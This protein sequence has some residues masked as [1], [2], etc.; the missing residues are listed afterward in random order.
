[1]AFLVITSG[2]CYGSLG[3]G[4]IY[5]AE[6]LLAKMPTQLKSLVEK[7]KSAYLAGANGVDIIYWAYYK[8]FFLYW[9]LPNS[10]AAEFDLHTNT[11]GYHTGQTALDILSEAK[12]YSIKEKAFALGWLTHWLTDAYVHTLIGHYGGDYRDNEDPNKCTPTGSCRHT[13]L[14]LAESK[15]LCSSERYA[16]YGPFLSTYT[17]SKGDLPEDFIEDLFKKHKFV[18]AKYKDGYMHGKGKVT[19][20]YPF[21]GKRIED[22]ESDFRANLET[23]RA[24][25]Q[26]AIECIQSSCSKKSNDCSGTQTG[27]MSQS[28]WQQNKQSY[29]LDK[30]DYIDINNAIR[31]N[32]DKL[33]VKDGSLRAVIEANDT[34][35]YGKFLVEW[36]KVISDLE[37][38]VD[39]DQLF[40]IVQAF[41]GPAE[42]DP[43]EKKA[44]EALERVLKQIP[45][46]LTPRNQ[47]HLFDPETTKR[48]A[49][50]TLRGAP[51]I[52]RIHYEI[53]STCDGGKTFNKSHSNTVPITFHALDKQRIK[54]FGSKS[55]SAVIDVALEGDE[56]K[57][58]QYVLLVSVVSPDTGV[59]SY[60]LGTAE[61][62][63]VKKVKVLTRKPTA[64]ADPDFKFLEYD[65]VYGDY[66]KSTDVK[67]R[68]E[69]KYE[70]MKSTIPYLEQLIQLDEKAF[71]EFEKAVRRNVLKGVVSGKYGAPPVPKECSGISRDDMA[72][73]IAEIEKV[74]PNA[75]KCGF[76]LEDPLTKEKRWGCTHDPQYQK[77]A[78][79]RSVLEICLK[80]Q[81][82]V[83]YWELKCIDTPVR[84]R[85]EHK[86]ML[87]AKLAA[88][89]DSKAY[90][91]FKEY[92]GY[93]DYKGYLKEI[94]GT[95]KE[96][97]LPD[98]IPSPVE[99]PWTYYSGTCGV[100]GAVQEAGKLQIQL[101]KYPE[102]N[103]YNVG[104]KITFT[105]EPTGGKAP[106]SFEWTGDCEGKDK[107]VAV[108][109]SKIGQ[110]RLKVSV[111][112]FRGHHG[113]CGCC[114]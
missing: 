62:G 27:S 20:Q 110:N 19:R 51:D 107:S 96:L 98:P 36:D 48:Y 28:V 84:E 45:N 89:K 52:T 34:Q 91:F 105:A 15:H 92:A 21:V 6:K 108:P 73:R 83:N 54:L 31:I 57:P 93:N 47:M 60:M 95:K 67:S 87:K 35:L 82:P 101:T 78:N 11:L 7:E 64:P 75:Y 104:E 56:D 69:A 80:G 39:K 86:E 63:G 13:Q 25:V 2:F 72:R 66:K 16:T 90:R 38:F 17:L 55:G 53:A 43:A 58:C 114:L 100:G 111:R 14:E 26:S 97:S 99:L 18:A 113:R 61:D 32:V 41:I 42:A 68:A 49:D 24:S 29:L 50:G 106:Y 3:Q 65:W 85:W 10:S 46:I 12:N 103:T 40:H 30:T 76:F 59:G 1:M 22:G 77:L 81:D 33:K 112:G 37:T 8:A 74:L 109:L 94:E 4:H 5:V 44:K 88:A 9:E 79:E 102:K 71:T 23:G 70:W